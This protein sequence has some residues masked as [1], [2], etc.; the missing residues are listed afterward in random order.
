M[1][2][3]K[4]ALIFLL[5][6]VTYSYAGEIK[7][8]YYFGNPTITKAGDYQSVNFDNCLMTAK[9]GD[10]ALPYYAVSLLLPPG[11]EAVSIQVNMSDKVSLK[12]S[13]KLYPYQSSRPLS[14]PDA[15]EF[16]INRSLYNS[17][18]NYPEQQH[19]R[20]STHY[21][22]GH[23]IAMTSITPVVYNPAHEAV[24]Y[25][26]QVTVTIETR[27]TDKASNALNKLHSVE[28]VKSF[29]DNPDILSRYDYKTSRSENTYKLLIITPENYVE[30]FDELRNIYLSRGITSEIITPNYIAT[31]VSGQDVQEQIRNYIIQEYEESNIE[32]VILGGDIDLVPYRGFYCYV[33]SG[34]G[35][36]TSDIPA[37]LYY[38]A[39]DGTW[40]D[41]G[42]G[43]WGEPDEDD[44]LPELAVGRFPF[45]D[46][47]EL[48][49]IIHKSIS[50][51][52]SPVLGEFTNNLMAG[53]FL[54]S[55][56]E[57]YG[58][59]YLDLLIGERSDNG[60]TTIGI[61]DNYTIDSIY[62]HNAPWNGTTLMA[63]IN[64]GKQ[65]IHHAGHANTSYVAHLNYNDITNANFSGANGID[66]NYTLFHTHGCDC[67]AFDTDCILE[68][69][70]TID[71]FAVSV[72]GNS[73]FG[74]FNEGQSEGP[75]AHLH[76]EMVDAMYNENMNHLGI[77]FKEAKTET[78][79]WVEAPGQWEEGALRWNFYDLN[80]LGDPVLSV[81]TD[82]PI[83]IEVDYDDIME[84]G[85]T[86]TTVTVTSNSIPMEDF[87]CSI[88]KDG[89]LHACSVT[90]N[91]GTA[92]LEFDPLVTELGEA[93]LIVTGY[94]CLPDT[95]QI[96]FISTSGAYVVYESHEVYDPDGNNN[97]IADFGES[98]LLNFTILNAGQGDANDINTVIS[99]EDEF[100]TITDNNENYGTVASGETKTINEA[101]AI[102]ISPNIPDQRVCV[103]NL[104]CESEGNTW[105]SNFS[106]I[107][108]A[109]VPENGNMSFND[110]SGNN[111]GYIDPGET[112]TLSFPVSN[113]GHSNCHETTVEII[114]DN[115]EIIL[116]QNYI[117]L[118]EINAGE[119]KTVSMDVTA[120]EAI[121]TGTDIMLK[122]YT[123]MCGYIDSASLFTTVGVVIE[124][125]ETG[126]FTLYPWHNTSTSPWVISQF[127]V[128]NGN[129]SAKSGS[130]SDNQS[131]S[132]D[133]DMIVMDEDTLSF[134]RKVSSEPQWDRLN[135]Y[136]NDELLGTWSGEVP[137]GTVSYIIQA[138]NYN[139][140]W[141]Y[142]K[143]VSSFSGSDCAWID[144]IVFP[145]PSVLTGIDEENNKSGISMYPNPGSGIYH[146]FASQGAT[147]VKI[148]NS[149]GSLVLD[150][151]SDFITGSVTIDISE[152]PAG[153]YFIE[154]AT[155]S[156]RSVG[157]I[158]KE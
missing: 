25:Y 48:E 144:D 75:A 35:Y 100:L 13:Y 102:D 136:I 47:D 117:N 121:I 3:K 14:K 32:Y 82:E 127:N 56:P 55:N 137:W 64:S 145:Q 24:S 140:K 59:D 22:S 130:I 65:F 28:K 49:N 98:I 87:T 132:L 147:S 41:D 126:D 37:D 91:S 105:L 151:Q 68:K 67:G 44:L 73:R 138:G 2:R 148:Y 80:I 77:A 21:L 106:I 33:Q 113:K 36:E 30:D 125:F 99:V 66:H 103:F 29:I 81:W 45:G 96:T 118:G 39:L 90:D 76:R 119:T 120:D 157:K 18:I 57:T 146:I 4:T 69:M 10:P 26:K 154:L 50:Y 153:I 95:N 124:D 83:S 139:V 54:Y 74:W 40:D 52:N 71:N 88:L 134:A 108:N 109:P 129:Y 43:L 112:V 150:K 1:N 89:I 53:E 115:P 135:L 131:S 142:A 149:T 116:S 7:K 5:A 60:Y 110:E 123:D 85:S 79:P 114:C 46:A 141:E 133:I 31:H 19:G 20:L 34:S 143:D 63:E 97:G 156:K 86:T 6:L 72:I 111:N 16:M 155:N 92:I 61:P 94:N 12:E 15:G 23:S 70:V 8:T 122:S 101:F 104:E 42:D 152:H 58:R 78:A 107:M 9:P 158:I 38:A 93:S 51:Q 17:N 27:Q 84:L 11:E 128:Y 62:E